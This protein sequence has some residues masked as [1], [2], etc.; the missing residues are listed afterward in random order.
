MVLMR[1][2]A[3]PVLRDFAKLNAL[4][5][6]GNVIESS[7]IGRSLAVDAATVSFA[8]ASARFGSQSIHPILENASWGIFL[9]SSLVLGL[10]AS[11]AKNAEVRGPQQSSESG[12]IVRRFV[13]MLAAFAFGTIGS[14][15]GGFCSYYVATMLA[16]G[17][18]LSQI[19]LIS[20]ALCASYIGGTINYFET[21]SLL[22]GFVDVNKS[23]L[24]KLVAGVDIAVMV[25]YFWAL[26][27]VR[28]VP[29]FS[30]I[31]SPEATG[32][33][34]NAL[35]A[36]APVQ[37]QQQASAKEQLQEQQQRQPEQ[38]P[39]QQP[40]QQPE[41][42]QE[43]LMRDRHRPSPLSYIPPL[44]AA[45]SI[46]TTGLW[47]Q[48]RVPIPGVSVMFS[49]LSSVCIQQLSKNLH[50]MHPTLGGPL[51]ASFGRSCQGASKYMLTLFY[52]SIG[53]GA[54]MGEL[55]SVGGPVLAVICTL[56]VVHLS[57]TL[58]LSLLW[59]GYMRRHHE[60]TR[61]TIDI[62]TVVVASNACVG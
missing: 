29:F 50:T 58:L 2:V 51:F 3:L 59:N 60:G 28:D 7:S 9:Q 41:Q 30:R 15:L 55:P 16:P 44:V 21:A 10:W 38:Q 26:A 62:D 17:C 6:F 37:S 33:D 53:I 5:A 4:A 47:V 20:S 43:V 25:L 35:T 39:E 52:A 49:V 13:P 31:F 34:Q 11:G 61:L 56:L 32:T 1:A 45:L 36:V 14:V 24:I 8:A 27:A 57:V 22:G 12:G 18:D 40:K 48:R 23:K 46:T 54:R 19:A 42:R